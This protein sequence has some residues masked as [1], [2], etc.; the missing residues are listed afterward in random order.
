MFLFRWIKRLIF[1]T[2]LAGVAYVAGGYISWHGRPARDQV[3]GFFRSALWKEGVKDMRVWLGA[4][5]QTAG[6]KI[7]EGVT[8]EDQRKLDSLIERDL[9]QQIESLQTPLPK[10]TEKKPTEAAPSPAAK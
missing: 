2:L 1:L 3:I 6:K 8:P 10:T 9:K 5:L 7:E 4:L